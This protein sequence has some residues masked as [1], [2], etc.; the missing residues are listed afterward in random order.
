V[1]GVIF[2]SLLL[3]HYLLGATIELSEIDKT[4]QLKLQGMQ[5]TLT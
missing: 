3:V 2:T 5:I 4:N 1:D